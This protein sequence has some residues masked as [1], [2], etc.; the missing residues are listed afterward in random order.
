EDWILPIDKAIASKIAEIREHY[1]SQRTLYANA[2][3]GATEQATWAKQEIE[4][5]A[6]VKDSMAET[7]LIDA[8]LAARNIQGETKTDLCNKIIMKADAYAVA[9]G[10]SLGIQQSKEKQAE[11]ATTLDDLDAITW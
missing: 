8:L 3:A 9:I 6:F 10:E 4:A 1:E 11:S 2:L 7:P 5:R